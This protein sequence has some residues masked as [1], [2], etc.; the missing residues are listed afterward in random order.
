[1]KEVRV[2]HINPLF[3]SFGYIIVFLSVKQCEFLLTAADSPFSL[4][5]PPFL[6]QQQH[7]HANVSGAPMQMYRKHT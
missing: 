7:T 2:F 6:Y 3:L 1:M 4:R 5:N